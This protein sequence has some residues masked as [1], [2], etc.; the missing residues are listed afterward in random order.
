MDLTTS[1][2][3]YRQTGYFSPT[4]LDYLDAKQAILPFLNHPVSI[5]GI[6]KSI[7]EKQQF[8]TARVLLT[9][10]LNK[11][12]AGVTTTASV[13]QNIQSLLQPTTF[14][15]CT[16]H[17]PNIFT[18]PLYFVYKILHAVKT[19]DLLNK[20]ITDAHFVPVYYMG[21]EDADLDELGHFF[22]NGDKYQW[23]TQQ[24]GAVGRMKID[25]ALI[26]LL[27]QLSGQLS[28]L[29]H[30]N[31]IID[32][33]KQCYQEGN[34]IETATFQ[35]VNQLFGAYGLIIL[36]PDNKELKAAF[37]PV[38]KQELLHAFSHQAVQETVAR[39]PE[40]YKAQASGR[41]INMFY[42]IDDKRERFEKMGDSW[43]VLNT[44]LQFTEQELLAELDLHPERFSPNVILRPV[45]Q[46]WILP[47]IAFIGGGGEIA[48]W[49]QLKGVFEKANV[50]YPMLIVR[51]S[52]M[53]ID[54]ASNLLLK[55]LRFSLEDI[56]K[57][58]LALMNQLVKRDSETQLSLEKE[59]AALNDLYVSIKNIA[60]KVDNTLSDHTMA[61]FT[62]ALKKIESL[63]K[64]ILKAEKKKFAAEQH[65]LSKLK[66]H[67]FPNNNLQER[68]E[69]MMP[70]YAKWG[71]GFI[72]AIYKNSLTLEQEFIILT[73]EN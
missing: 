62:K 25:A 13:Q 57:T 67:L 7:R 52:F 29:P 26:K 68:V 73:E 35:L 72:D 23:D 63:E 46:E 55:N 19:A 9:D 5:D 66:S 59:K 30:G 60:G 56:F 61:L 4:V 34:T 71:R 28:V 24:T 41:E 64:K 22:V 36:L 69:N 45:F 49:L 32:L 10:V 33:M 37:Q 54:K 2:L 15:I 50:P 17:Q 53:I 42:L 16:A 31:E 27:N 51:N 65:K 44:D 40:N 3:P 39:F 18:G 38:I 14:T 43:T 48:Y 8:S 11:Q 6:K 21:S 70:F 20:T 58:E 47:N 12:Y 1:L